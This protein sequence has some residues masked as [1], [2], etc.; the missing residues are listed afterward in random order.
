MSGPVFLETPQHTGARKDSSGYLSWILQ[1]SGEKF[2]ARQ[3]GETHCNLKPWGSKGEGIGGQYGPPVRVLWGLCP[4][5]ELS[6][7]QA[8][9]WVFRPF[10]GMLL[11]WFSHEYPHKGHVLR[12]QNS[13]CGATEWQL[14]N[15]GADLQR[16]H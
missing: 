15:K 1:H 9:F 10:A 14:D 4:A 7:I 5:V 13:P 2:A 16:S 12:A 3:D 6:G 8:I 11:W